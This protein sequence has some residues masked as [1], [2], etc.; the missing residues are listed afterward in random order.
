MIKIILVD[1]HKIIRDGISAILKDE[2]DIE[3]IGE[4]E[5]GEELLQV[6]NSLQPDV[7][8]LDILMPGMSGYDAMLQL[9]HKYPAVKVLVLS[10][11]NNEVNINKMLNAGALGYVLKNTGRQELVHAIKTV[12]SGHPYIGM[13]ISMA[14]LKKISRPRSVNRSNATEKSKAGQ[15]HSVLT[16]RELEVLKLIAEG[17]TNAEIAEQLFTS[18]RTIE[19]HRQN[20]ME[21]IQAKNT[22]TLIKYALSEGIV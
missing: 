22:A 6:L 20:L 17:Y 2:E 5:N 21:K 10:M 4:A 14:M 18:K 8:I 11:L 12:A 1:D 13:D 19:T 9:L 16:P 7:V 15:S 3:I